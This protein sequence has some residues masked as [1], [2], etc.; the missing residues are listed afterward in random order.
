MHIALPQTLCYRWCSTHKCSATCK[1][2]LSCTVWCCSISLCTSTQLL[3]LL[4]TTTA[5]KSVGAPLRPHQQHNQQPPLPRLLLQHMFCCHCCSCCW[6]FADELAAAVAAAAA[7]AASKPQS[8]CCCCCLDDANL[9]GHIQGI[10]VLC[11]AHI[12]LLLTIRPAVID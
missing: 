12:G 3:L 10:K 5:P 11:E 1:R 9:V 2:T 4:Q 7:A 8:S 6:C